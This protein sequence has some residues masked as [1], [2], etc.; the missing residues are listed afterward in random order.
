MKRSILLLCLATLLSS[1]FGDSRL[2]VI[3]HTKSQI[4]FEHDAKN[5][6]A[7]SELNNTEFYLGRPLEV[8]DST[9]VAEYGGSWPNFFKR[10]KFQKLNL[11][12]FNF[13]TLKRYSGINYLVEHKLYRRFE[14]SE[15]DLEKSNWQIIV[16]D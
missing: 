16:K 11:F 6:L 14:F 1:C 2:M 8:G 5:E 15:A 7:T 12:I 13:D 9:Y 3:N 4:V 10:S